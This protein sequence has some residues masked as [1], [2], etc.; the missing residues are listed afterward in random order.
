[1]ADELRISG[2]CV[3]SLAELA[4]KYLPY[5]TA[6]WAARAS[7]AVSGRPNSRGAAP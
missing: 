3:K 1:M 5:G 6:K 4:D 2:K 7:I